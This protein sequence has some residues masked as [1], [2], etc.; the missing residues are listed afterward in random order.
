MRE[1]ADDQ[2]LTGTGMVV[3]SMAHLDPE[4]LES[5]PVGPHSDLFCLGATLYFEVEG[6]APFRRESVGATVKAIVSDRPVPLRRAGPLAPLLHRLLDPDPAARPGTDEVIGYL[7]LLLGASAADTHAAHRSAPAPPPVSGR[8][9][10]APR[11]PTEIVW[12]SGDTAGGTPPPESV[13]AAHQRQPVPGRP[14]FT[15]PGGLHRRAA[16]A[17]R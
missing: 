17:F 6:G 5:K 4:R 9:D 7:G 14:D 11:T 16:R 10:A 1:L 15:E 3:G 12:A 2:R 8:A 13:P